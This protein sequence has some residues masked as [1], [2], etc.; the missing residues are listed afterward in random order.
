MKNALRFLLLISAFAATATAAPQLGIQSW[1]CRNMSF[2]ETVLFAEK[3]GITQ[4]EFYRAH[5]DPNGTEAETARKLAFLKEHG[6]TAYSIG[7]SGTSLNKEENRKLFEFAQRCGIKVIVVEPGDPLIWDNLEEL[8]REYDI[9]LAVHN[10]GTGTTY[11]NPSVV[12]HILAERDPRIGVCLDI[13]WVTAAGFDAATV[14]KNY[15]DRVFDMHLKDK[16]LD[17]EERPGRPMGTHIGLG[18]SNYVGVF[19]ALRA[20]DWSGVMALETDN[21][22]FAADPTEFVTRGKAYFESFFPPAT[23]N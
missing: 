13:G 21:P 10:H 17:Q 8:V 18:N 15:G 16:R 5:L 23:K 22:D 20:S 3:H 7:V 2:E 11:G 14:L 19:E 6:V 9:K 4:I 12:K 1:T